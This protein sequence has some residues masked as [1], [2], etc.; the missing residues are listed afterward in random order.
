MREVGPL[1]NTLRFTAA[2][3]GVSYRPNITDVVNTD[4]SFAQLQTHYWHT[5]NEATLKAEWHSVCV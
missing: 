2:F 1:N 3:T 4:I 5:G